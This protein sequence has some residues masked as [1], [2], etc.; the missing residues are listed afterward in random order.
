[1]R[2]LILPLASILVLSTPAASQ[3]AASYPAAT[4]NPDSGERSSGAAVPVCLAVAFAET[5]EEAWHDTYATLSAL[6]PAGGAGCEIIVER[7]AE[8]KV[9]VP[10]FLDDPIPGGH[11][12]LLE[13]IAEYDAA[14]VIIVHPGPSDSVR[15]IPGTAGFT[16]PGWLV[17]ETAEKLRQSFV[18]FDFAE[19]RLPLYR[20]GWMEGDPDAAPYLEAGIPA[21]SVETNMD[22]S[23][24]L[25]ALAD[26]FAKGIPASHD[27][28][29]HIVRTASA[30]RILGERTVVLSIVGTSALILFVMFMF[31]FVFGRHRD[32]HR[33]DLYRIWWMPVVYLALNIACLIAARELVLFLFKFRFNE[34]GAINYLS[35]QAF[36]SKIAFA[37]FFVS[38]FE[39]FNQLIR[40]PSDSF[41]Y[42]YMAS[43]VCLINVFIFSSVDFS[44]TPLFLA[45]YAITYAFHYFR[46][47]TA[48][49]AAIP[50]SLAPFAHYIQVLFKA[51]PAALEPLTDSNLSVTILLAFLLLPAQLL[52]LRFLHSVGIFGK[53]AKKFI[54]FNLIASFAAAVG[55]LCVLLFTPAWSTDNPLPVLLHERLDSTGASIETDLPASLAGT[56]TIFSEEL[57]AA[58][59]A[60]F[61]PESFLR[62]SIESRPFLDRRLV[63]LTAGSMLSPVRI[64]VAVRGN[65]GITVYDASEQFELMS[66]G[67]EA[68]FTSEL[69]PDAV[70]EYRF[71]TSDD[72]DLEAT[73]TVWSLENPRGLALT[74]SEIRSSYV[75]EVERTFSIPLDG[76]AGD[77]L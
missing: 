14:V 60:P 63:T 44:L 38:L 15:I 3:A 20:L 17:R 24:V 40:F 4:Q 10:A 46:H 43:V 45:V 58:P 67:L 7:T 47:P 64:K 51:G 25:Q 56:G 32:R 50:L 30:W 23:P 5:A 61:A 21:I 52:F 69:F 13:R 6:P 2:R 12:K 74:V 48:H 65:T 54:P 28:H 59:L 62:V 33:R 27:R 71:S 16:S 53:R 72:P 75:F 55:F 1:M 76:P 19:N 66:G 36:V 8:Q 9:P 29:Y 57:A 18:P 11:R 34:I 49:L 39:S 31:A 73:V 22:I 37:L 42:G 77:P 70:R 26:S 35:I 68:V 41:V